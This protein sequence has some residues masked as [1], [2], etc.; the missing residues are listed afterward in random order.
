MNYTILHEM[1]ISQ[2]QRDRVDIFEL[3]EWKS[4]IRI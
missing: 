2:L 4:E 3:G 1:V